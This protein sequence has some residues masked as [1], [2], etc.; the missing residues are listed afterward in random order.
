[1]EPVSS[2]VTL[3]DVEKATE[4]APFNQL[5]AVVDQTLAEPSPRQSKFEGGCRAEMTTVTRLVNAL[6]SLADTRKAKLPRPE[7]PG[8]GVKTAK[9]ALERE[10]LPLVAFATV[11]TAAAFVKPEVYCQRSTVTGVLVVV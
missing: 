1:F 7:K 8:E 4:F 3:S 10:T 11:W 2:N 5:E 6:P 9:W